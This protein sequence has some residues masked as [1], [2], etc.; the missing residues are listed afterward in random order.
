MAQGK[1]QQWL[2]GCG[3]RWSI[4]ALRPDLGRLA[5]AVACASQAKHGRGKIES[6]ATELL[7]TSTVHIF[8]LLSTASNGHPFQVSRSATASY[9][10]IYPT[11]QP[12]SPSLASPSQADRIFC[13]SIRSEPIENRILGTLKRKPDRQV[14]RAVR[15]VRTR[16]LYSRYIRYRHTDWNASICAFRRVATRPDLCTERCGTVEV[17][18]TCSKGREYYTTL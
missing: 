18:Q 12:V 10:R 2:C 15:P 11:T 16:I 14:T 8:M 4:C 3:H 7:C 17:P 5:L 1:R 9:R 13:R 6:T